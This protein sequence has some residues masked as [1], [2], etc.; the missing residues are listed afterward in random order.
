MI[1]KFFK[2][3]PGGG[4]IGSIKYL[5]NERVEYGEARILNGNAELTTSII[6]S[7]TRK[8]KATVGCISFE[9]KNIKEDLKYKLMADLEK[10][11][12]PG[13]NKS[14]YNILWVE[15]TDKEHLELN[16]VIPKTELITNKLLTPYYHKQD[17]PRLEE[18]EKINNLKYNFTNP[19]DPAKAKNI[20]E[21]NT[22]EKH[23]YTNYEEFDL[24]LKAK[25]EAGELTNRDDLIK[26]VKSQ[27][28]EV[29][30]TRK[31]GISIKLE[32]SKKAKKFDND[33]Y[34]DKFISLE[35]VN[36]MQKTK[37]KASEDF[38]KDLA[39]NRDALIEE[40]TKK[41]D[42]LNNYKAL[43]FAEKYTP[44]VAKEPKIIFEK[45]KEQ[46]N[47]NTRN[48]STDAI[49]ESEIREDNRK[50]LSKRARE[51]YKSRETVRRENIRKIS[52]LSEKSRERTRAVRIRVQED[53]R[54]TRSNL[55]TKS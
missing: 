27:G 51:T 17:L 22:K 11:L 33:I 13:M 2:K 29:T 45:V 49:K 53:T 16:F 37:E 41:L 10:T 26:Y 3:P 18:F 12:F 8:D 30:R 9:E 4:G 35:S 1:V 54:A 44:I 28:H 5:L 24:H 50:K 43:V 55:S 42:S 14:Q 25:V 52:E 46:K 7:I 39:E 34:S 19:L 40:Y 6:E 32:D 21:A 36:V 23:L 38:K 47:E 31:N 48:T 15:H 20:Q